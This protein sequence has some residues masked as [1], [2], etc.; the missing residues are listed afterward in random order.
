MSLADIPM[1][2]KFELRLSRGN[3]I[4]LHPLRAEDIGVLIQEFEADFWSIGEIAKRQPFS[5]RDW[6]Q[7]L[8]ALL[9]FAPELLAH[10]IA[11]SAREPHAVDNATQLPF[12]VV[13]TAIIEIVRLS[14]GDEGFDYLLE[15]LKHFRSDDPDARQRWIDRGPAFNFKS[16]EG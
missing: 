11:L 7:F 6:L 9:N 2:E 4:T 10:V 5:N 14:S 1:P 13:I 15:G 8:D 16:E 12:P 3:T